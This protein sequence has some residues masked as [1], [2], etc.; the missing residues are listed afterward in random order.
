M[1]GLPMLTWFALTPSCP[2]HRQG[3][4]LAS[5][6]LY[7]PGWLG[8]P[9]FF[10]IYFYFLK[11]MQSLLLESSRDIYRWITGTVRSF[12]LPTPIVMPFRPQE[13]LLYS[14]S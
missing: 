11:R 12:T 4:H 6:H 14:T 7:F 3:N 10:L 2:K 8:K 9:L 1:K 13:R 5:L